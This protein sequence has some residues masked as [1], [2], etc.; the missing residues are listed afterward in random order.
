M[1]TKQFFLPILFL[2]LATLF[3]TSCEADSFDEEIL[4]IEPEE[5]EDPDD[6]GN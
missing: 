6:R 5:V 2:F 1:K 4:Q 3:L